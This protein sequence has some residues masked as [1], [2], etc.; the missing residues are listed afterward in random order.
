VGAG[1]RGAYLDALADGPDTGLL[2]AKPVIRYTGAAGHPLDGLSFSTGAFADPQGAGTFGGMA[3]RIGEIEDPDAPAHNPSRDFVLECD[4]VWESGTLPAYQGQIQIPSGALKLGR[5]Y[6]A[7]VK[8]KDN[9]GRWSH[10]SEPYS[11]TTAPPTNLDE[12]QQFLMITEVMYH[13]PG[14]AYPGATEEEFEFIELQNISDS[15]TLDLAGVRF[16]QGVDFNF[17]DG[18][19]TLL[20]PGDRVLVVKNR[21]AFESRYGTG[22][23]VAGEWE[24]GDL[25]ANSGEQLAIAFGN[26]S[27]IHN[28]IYDDAAPWPAQ[29]DGK[30]PSMVLID[31]RSAPDHALAASWKASHGTLGSPGFRDGP[32]AT[33]MLAQEASDPDAEAAPGMSYAMMYA[34]GGDLVATPRDAL[35]TASFSAGTGDEKH[36]TLSYRRRIGASDVTYAVETATDLETWQSGPAAVEPFGI[37]VPN[38]DGTETVQ[39]RVIAPVSADPA[40][41]IRLRITVAD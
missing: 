13:P 18:D 30:G 20:F 4:P 32:F 33:W 40:R 19:I 29:A 21:A 41:F 8:M 3:W 36:L 28:F 37:P 15:V 9:T 27:D 7:R 35:P 16:H 12:L 39:V 5:T 2:P 1:G 11:F 23:P 10:W 38:G 22:L 26:D 17:E 14:P 24:A 34:L 31:P 6:R 25:L